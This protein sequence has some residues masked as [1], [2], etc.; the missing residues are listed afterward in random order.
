MPNGGYF[1]FDSLYILWQKS[2][3]GASFSSS[4]HGLPGNSRLPGCPCPCPQ[5]TRAQPVR[6]LAELRQAYGREARVAR[7][8]YT[9]C[10][11]KIRVYMARVCI[12]QVYK[13]RFLP[14]QDLHLHSPHGPGLLG[15]HV[16]TPLIKLRPPDPEER[17]CSTSNKACRRQEW[18]PHCGAEGL[19]LSAPLGP[20]VLLG[21]L[22]REPVS[23]SC[24]GAHGPFHHLRH[25]PPAF[26][27]TTSCFPV[28]GD[29]REDKERSC[30]RGPGRRSLPLWVTTRGCLPYL[31]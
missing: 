21:P 9:A 20:R 12:A 22:S 29:R 5:V 3:L 6:K 13:A 23:S 1:T 10:V 2:S 16:A 30:A 14:H 18:G 8:V 24:P 19:D 4:K 28:A 7:Q 27:F 26:S 11:C 15:T 25:P 31:S 17:H